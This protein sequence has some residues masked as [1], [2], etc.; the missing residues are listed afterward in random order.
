M[1]TLWAFLLVGTTSSIFL[2]WLLYCLVLCEFKLTIVM[3]IRLSYFFFSSWGLLMAGCFVLTSLIFSLEKWFNNKW[4]FLRWIRLGFESFMHLNVNEWILE[5]VIW[6]KSSKNV[7][8]PSIATW[9][10][11]LNLDHIYMIHW[12]KKKKLCKKWN[13]DTKNIWFLRAYDTQ[14]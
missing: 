5:I 7:H 4:V 10:T 11:S 12:R 2:F 3:S 14:D 1:H 13:I 6:K 9:L 8:K